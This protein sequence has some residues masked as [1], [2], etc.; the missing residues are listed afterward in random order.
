MKVKITVGESWYSDKVNAIIEVTER[1][2]WFREPDSGERVPHYQMAEIP[3]I[4]GLSLVRVI[5][6]RHAVVVKD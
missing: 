5:D 4:G 1:K 3:T 6:C 2:T